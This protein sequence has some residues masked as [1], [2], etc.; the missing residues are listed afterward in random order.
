MRKVILK[1]H[2]T[3][4]MCVITV[5]DKNQSTGM[6]QCLLSAD[7]SGQNNLIKRELLEY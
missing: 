7:L 2:I 1:A 4:R 5:S 3:K 6:N